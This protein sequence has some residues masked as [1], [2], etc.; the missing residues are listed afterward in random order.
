MKQINH[1]YLYTIARKDIPLAHQTIQAAHA[2]IEYARLYLTIDDGHPSYVHLTAKNK[3]ALLKIKESLN[4]A[5]IQTAEFH[6]PYFNSEL[7][8]ISCLL[9]EDQRHFLA[10]LQLWKLPTQAEMAT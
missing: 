1:F 5:G 8:A 7:T 10:H 9:T 4:S 6:E 3:E 2:G